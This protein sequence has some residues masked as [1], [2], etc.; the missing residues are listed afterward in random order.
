MSVWFIPLLMLGTALGWS[1]YTRNAMAGMR[2]SSLTGRQQ[3]EPGSVKPS[4]RAVAV[5]P[6][7]CACANARKLSGQRFLSREAPILP[8]RDCGNV[9]CKCTYLH[10]A[11]R[12]GP[13]RRHIYGCLSKSQRGL[14]NSTDRRYAI[15]RR[16]DSLSNDE[17]SDSATIYS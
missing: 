2:R 11:D 4:F 5:N 17:Y 7:D 16:D 1:V 14:D 6:G 12:R 10:H 13:E 9:R 3:S 8:L 15:D